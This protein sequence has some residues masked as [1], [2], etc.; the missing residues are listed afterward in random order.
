M[1]SN[2]NSSARAP[3]AIL[4]D[5]AAAVVVADAADRSSL[6]SLSRACEELAGAL[7]RDSDK[8][9]REIAD[10]CVRSLAAALAD[11]SL[12]TGA[13]EAANDAVTR[14]QAQL[15][16]HADRSPSEPRPRAPERVERDADTV[17]LFGDFL[18]ESADGLS[19]ADQILMAVE[20]QGANAEHV[21]SLFRVFH[22]IKGT[23]GFL[24]LADVVE[25]AHTTETMLNLCRQGELKLEG[26][27]VDLCLEATTVMRAMLD[28]V[29][30]A[31]EQSLPFGRAVDLTG[32]LGRIQSVIEAAHPAEAPPAPA[33][34]APVAAAPSAKAAPPPPAAKGAPPGS[35]TSAAAAPAATAPAAPPVPPP[36]AHA[37]EHDAPSPAP[38]GDGAHPEARATAADGT[39]KLKETLKV[40]LER[41]DS[42]VAMIGELVV[43]ESMVVNAPEIVQGA[44]PR[45]R[46]CLAQLAKVTRDLQDVGMRMR[47][48][49][50]SGVFQKMA[51]LVRDLGRKSGKQVRCQLSGEATEMDRSMVEQ[52]ADPLVHLV[53]NACDH[54]VEAADAR[55]KAGKSAEATVRL[56]AYHEGGSI[57]IELSDDGRGLDREAIV[58]KA[59]RQ[60]LIRSA[61]G[62]SEADVDA[63]IFAPGF[64]TAKVVTEVSG[65]GVGMD[66]V[67][68]NVEALRGRVT[69]HS[70]PGQGTTFKLVLPLTLAIIDGMLVACGEERY[71]IPTLSIVESLRPERQM[72]VTM[73][74]V[75]EMVNLRGEILPL[76]R[77]DALFGV[78]G[79][80][81]DPTQALVVV[82]EG[83]G[84][85]VGLL[86]D[87]VVAQ[88][89]VVIK[90]LG[91]GLGDTPYV[92][93]GAILSDGRVGLILNVEQIVGLSQRRAPRGGAEGRSKP[94]PS[95][96]KPARPAS[97]EVRP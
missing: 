84:R 85:R 46:N 81:T 34:K 74:Q 30:L 93:G 21:N 71:I 2:A 7:R 68:R 29:K 65:R 88:Q 16:R 10:G 35:T 80:R 63:L 54:G 22:T 23:A 12:A 53:R 52:I 50:V 31:V 18:Q 1:S 66:V 17:S 4:E 45:V 55:A 27:P 87:E 75:N 82:V 3:A 48:V 78:D 64:S 95:T 14:L 33:A 92:A 9:M 76:L 97:T 69:I 6:E 28:A 96:P 83:V 32:L 11:P 20:E 43:V 37:V 90:T 86:V 61:D 40:D 8:G 89:Q 72:L 51:R 60:G 94:V 19:R 13:L 5:V 59:I 62:M 57:V 73:A 24:D 58:A 41:V 36:A 56:S 26:E 25:L 15:A 39:V 77:L 38:G 70:R 79:A 42:L 91:E 49:P 47:M 67:K 44:T